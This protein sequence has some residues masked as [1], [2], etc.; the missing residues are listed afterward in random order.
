MNSS[1]QKN[2]FKQQRIAYMVVVKFL[3]LCCL[4]FVCLGC[5]E[6]DLISLDF[7]YAAFCEGDLNNC[8]VSA[9]PKTSAYIRQVSSIEAERKIQKENKEWME[10]ALK[11][12]KS[13]ADPIIYQNALLEFY[14]NDVLVASQGCPFRIRIKETKGVPLLGDWESISVEGGIF[15]FSGTIEKTVKGKDVNVF[16]FKDSGRKLSLW[17]SNDF[18][19]TQVAVLIDDYGFGIVYGNREDFLSNVPDLKE[20]A[21]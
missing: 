8:V 9:N 18:K 6:R 10:K 19:T 12:A 5:E 1:I 15:E 11:E 20:F 13:K 16:L 3:I 17:L 4:T 21:K 14:K 2:L 7:K